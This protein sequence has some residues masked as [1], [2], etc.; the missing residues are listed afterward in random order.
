MKQYEDGY[1]VNGYSWE[2]ETIEYLLNDKQLTDNHIP[3]W[4]KKNE[5]AAFWFWL[6]IINTDPKLDWPPESPDNQYHLNK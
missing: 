5:I 6:V 3:E 4:V 2:N 1:N